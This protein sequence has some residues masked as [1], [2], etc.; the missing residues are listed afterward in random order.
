MS[1]IEKAR[2]EGRAAAERHHS[3]MDHCPYSYSRIGKPPQDVFER[4]YRPL[5][6]AWFDGWKSWLDE[7]GLGF[8]FQPKKGMGK[9]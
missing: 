1:D 8:N 9:K 2:T 7:H 4:Q 5:M 3:F 6:N